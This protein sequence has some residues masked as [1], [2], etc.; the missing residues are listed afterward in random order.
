MGP[1]SRAQLGISS[2]LCPPSIS[3]ALRTYPVTAPDIAVDTQ[4]FT[5]TPFLV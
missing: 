4:P 2:D 5:V 1:H 3:T